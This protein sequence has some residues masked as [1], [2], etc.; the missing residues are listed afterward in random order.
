M[1]NERNM[2]EK[3]EEFFDDVGMTPSQLLCILG[4]HNSRIL[5]L[6]ERGHSKFSEIYEKIIKKDFRQKDK[7][8]LLE[9]LTYILFHEGYPGLFECRKNCRTSSNEID[10]LLC[11]TENARMSGMNRAFSC[12]DD[13]FMCECKNYVKKVD[14]TYV[15]KFFSLLKVTNSKLGIM[16][17][18]DGI[19]ARS[20][21][22]DS[23][24][25]IKKIALGDKVYII[26]IDRNDLDKIYRQET[27]IFSIIC[28]KYSALKNDIDY[29]EYVKKHEAEIRFI[30]NS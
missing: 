30:K 26:P 9:E 27:N 24:G 7:G 2:I 15:G 17:A 4:K 14:V 13:I 21:W 23:S 5:Q 8:K 10:L 11:W 29:L 16:I 25:L 12:F 1:D 19:T 20:K 22:S 18:W 6:D 28:N 3:A